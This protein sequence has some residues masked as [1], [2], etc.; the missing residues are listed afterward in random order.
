MKYTICSLEAG[1]GDYNVQVENDRIKMNSLG[2]PKLVSL[3]ENPVNQTYDHY[4]TS[5]LSTLA[6]IVAILDPWLSGFITFYKYKE[7]ANSLW[8]GSRWTM[9]VYEDPDTVGLACPSYLDTHE[10]VMKAMTKMIVYMA[11]YTN[12]LHA[13]ALLPHRRMNADLLAEKSEI[14]G[15]KV[16]NHNVYNTE[17]QFFVISAVIE[18]VCIALVAPTY[19][20][21]WKLGR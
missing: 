13:K 10:D 1:I 11:T 5:H 17:Y 19:W 9:E 3:L 7:F 4:L 14:T 20:G 21:W 6:P 18:V 8:G 2:A 16:G 15:Y 12:G